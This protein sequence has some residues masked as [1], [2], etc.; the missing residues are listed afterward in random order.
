MHYFTEDPTYVLIA[1]GLGALCCLAALKV[2]QRGRYL[3]W[4]GVLAAVAAGVFG[5]ERL[6]VTDAERIEGV[7]YDLARA[8]EAS[9]VERIKSHLDD[10]VTIGM[11]GRTMDGS[12]PMRLVFGLLQRT[13]FDFVR[14]GQLT[15]SAGRQTRMGTASFKVSGTGIFEEGG[16][17]HPFGSTGS[18]WS[19]SFSERGP[20]VWKV[21]RIQ[22]IKVPSE[23]ARYLFGR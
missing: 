16:S 11:R 15:T 10:R 8:M 1:L 6:Y 9:D 21:T 22:A 3:V 7:V 18:E 2:T 4:A 19:L 5:F 14:I 23:V 17:E 12:I 20:G 13:R